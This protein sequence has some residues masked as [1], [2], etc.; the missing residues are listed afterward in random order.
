[1]RFELRAEEACLLLI[2]ETASVHL[3]SGNRR[4]FRAQAITKRSHL[5]LVF[6]LLAK[7]TNPFQQLRWWFL[8]ASVSNKSGNL[9]FAQS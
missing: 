5:V 3:R 2:F 9:F 7:C 1:M 8:T 4:L 6:T